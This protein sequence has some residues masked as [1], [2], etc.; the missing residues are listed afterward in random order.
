MSLQLLLSVVVVCVF[1]GSWAAVDEMSER[2]ASFL[3]DNQEISRLGESHDAGGLSELARKIKEKWKDTDMDSYCRLMN[4]LCGAFRTDFD[5]VD[6]D[7]LRALSA[8]VLSDLEMRLKQSIDPVLVRHYYGFQDW[9][10]SIRYVYSPENEKGRLDDDAWA[11]KRKDVISRLLEAWK[12]VQDAKDPNWSRDYPLY[13]KV[14]PPN[15][16]PIG[17]GPDSIGDPA[18]RAKFETDIKAN[19]EKKKW[20]SVQ[21]R[22]S[23]TEGLLKERLLNDIKI[24]Y[25]TPPLAPE[26]LKGLLDTYVKD[27][28]QK[29][30]FLEPSQK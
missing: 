27:E 8:D 21:N 18:L 28:E 3:S 7:K 10:I 23:R 17:V 4:E 11:Y 25:N 20:Y 24:M 6:W 22:L 19:E 1:Q 12:L 26:E 29:K 30:M 9:Y 5:P 2:D 16:A 15:G 13:S 14:P